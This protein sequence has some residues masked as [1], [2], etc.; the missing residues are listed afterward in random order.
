MDKS[1]RHNVIFIV[2]ITNKDGPKIPFVLI[3][4]KYCNEII[5]G[6]NTSPSLSEGDFIL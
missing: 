6:Y 4:D 5:L 1:A 2:Y 3:Q